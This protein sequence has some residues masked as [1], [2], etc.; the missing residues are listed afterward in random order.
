[1]LIVSLVFDG[2]QASYN[3][4]VSSAPFPVPQR[5]VCPFCRN[6]SDGSTVNLRDG[7]T[8]QCAVV[9]HLPDS[10]SFLNPSQI[11]EPHVL[12]IPTRHAATVLD[13]TAEEMTAIARQVHRLAAAVT[14][15]FGP[16]GLN[17]YQNNGIAAGQ[18]VGHYHVH[19]VPRYPGQSSAVISTR[20]IPPTPIERRLTL[21]AR[22]RDYLESRHRVEGDGL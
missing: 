3:R 17:I 2:R 9:E 12:V 7:R 4:R 14:Q 11:A 6:I 1:M 5:E 16:L 13:L 10:F 15:A 21:A 19:V 22:I 8:T 20:D 18:S